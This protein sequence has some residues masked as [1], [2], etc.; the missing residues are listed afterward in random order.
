MGKAREEEGKRVHSRGKCLALL[1]EFIAAD[2][3][4]GG[5]IRARAVSHLYDHTAIHAYKRKYK[6][7]RD[8]ASRGSPPSA[9]PLQLCRMH[10]GSM[11]LLEGFHGIRTRLPR[12]KCDS[13]TESVH[14]RR[15]ERRPS[16]A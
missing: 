11:T 5:L 13:D 15:F 4:R 6:S 9:S 8:A 12:N 10:H 7:I 14:C 3:I 16:G 1:D 2:C